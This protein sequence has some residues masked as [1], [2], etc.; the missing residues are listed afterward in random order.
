MLFFALN[1]ASQVVMIDYHCSLVHARFKV[2]EYLVHFGKFSSN[3]YDMYLAITLALTILSAIGL[4]IV[5]ISYA[6]IRELR[7]T[8]IG[9]LV[10]MLAIS[11][12]VY[13]IASNTDG[14]MGD[15]TTQFVNN[16]NTFW[17]LAIAY[18]TFVL[19][20]YSEI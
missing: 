13:Y 1:D 14:L 12:A 2:L 5:A 7:K 20:K 19:L 16:L 9:K 11:V 17:F 18:E 10:L 6:C 3:Q 4:F 8:V 15:L